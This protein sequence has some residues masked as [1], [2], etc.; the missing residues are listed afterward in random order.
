MKQLFTVVFS[1]I[2]FTT[3]ANA[4]YIC[5]L[6]D[7]APNAPQ[8]DVPAATLY[9]NSTDVNAS[10]AACSAKVDRQNY[11]DYRLKWANEADFPANWKEN[12]LVVVS[13]PAPA[14]T[15]TESSSSTE[16]ATQT[17]TS[18]ESQ[19]VQSRYACHIYDKRASEPNGNVP[20]ATFYSDQKLEVVQPACIKKMNELL[21]NQYHDYEVKWLE[22]FP[23]KWEESK[24]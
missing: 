12:E 3:T 16:T 19:P 13:A 8:G 21:P 20:F 22:Q 9:T 24:L 4:A 15:T 14:P 5:E 2:A 1:S 11:I 6:F 18:T 17:S 10:K 23:E 7:R